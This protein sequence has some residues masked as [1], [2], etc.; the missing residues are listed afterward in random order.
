MV[1]TANPSYLT[2]SKDNR[3]V[4]AVNEEETGG[5]SSFKWNKDSTHLELISQLPTQGIHPCYI[6]LNSTED[7]LAVAN[8]T[9]GNITSFGVNKKGEINT[10]PQVIQHAGKGPVVDR[11]E[12]P[13]AHCSIFRG[14]NYLYVVDLGI[15]QIIAYPIKDGL[16]GEPHIAFDLNPGDGPRHLIFHPTKDYAFVINE[17]SNTLV[18]MKV[19]HEK[20]TFEVITRESTLPDDFTEQS[21][22]ADIHLSADGKFLYASNRGHDSIAIFSVS[23]EGALQRI[24]TESTRGEWPRNFTL[25]PDGNYLLVANQYTDNIVVFEVDKITGLLSYTGTEVEVFSPVCLKF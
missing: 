23:E 19:D 10:T 17:L 9:S 4:Y 2:I 24:G 20:G 16:L 15:D 11:Q 25:S 5:V 14:D 22:C 18:S 6:D 21:Q 3:F 1:L 7:V 12:G 8:Y 13:H